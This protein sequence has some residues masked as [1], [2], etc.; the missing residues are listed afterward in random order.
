MPVP[1][2]ALTALSVA[3]S[4][5]TGGYATF[6]PSLFV[7][8]ISV[9]A[10]G[11]FLHCL[12]KEIRQSIAINMLTIAI[13]LPL[14]AWTLPALWLL[15][16]IMCLW[17]P[18]AAGRF[19]LIVPVYLFSLLLL[20]GLDK[21]LSIG[22]LSLFEFNVYNALALGAA[23]AIFFNPAK[24][25]SRPEWD[26]V[27]LS[28]VVLIAVALFRGT[29]L[30]HHAR[31]IFKLTIDLG[32]PYYVASRGLRNSSDLRMALIWL[33][34]G[35]VNASA[36]LIFEVW[37]G[38]PIYNQLFHIYELPTRLLVKQ[39]GGL[40]RAAGP[41]IE[42]TGGAMLLTLCTLALYVMRDAF[43]GRAHYYL[44]LCICLVGIFAPQS[45][46]A[47]GG[48][49]FAIVI[50]D[51][52]RRRY[53]PLAGKV[54]VLAGVMSVLLLTAHFSPFVSEQIGLSGGSR[55]TVDYRQVLFDRG[56]EEFAKR[57]FT[58]Y[59]MD[60]LNIH[61]QDLVQGEGII[62]FVNAYIWILLISGAGGLMIFLGAIGYFL[63][64]VTRAVRLGGR[65]GQAIEAGTFTVAAIAVFAEMFF[66]TSFGTR[67]AI[68]MLILFGFAVAYI[69]LQKSP[70]VNDP[71]V[72]EGGVT[73]AL[74]SG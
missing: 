26:V 18:V 69:R 4:L 29:S 27:A 34:A 1:I 23:V 35:A 30:S 31:G 45:R 6:K 64:K 14:L 54:A 38:W 12:K 71:S 63:W 70:V 32:L 9:L 28:I 8:I 55:D 21:T 65:G 57:P 53:F 11:L 15:F 37:K 7:V 41:F 46:S 51:I 49:L 74:T 3:L 44:L 39:R 48:L 68:F 20:P 36:I 61:L 16:V 43:R 72:E 66:F 40:L 47:W 10:C 56:L 73:A 2:I 33:A 22:S 17:V 19:G 25:R 24:A 50:V 52:L 60:E 5:L 42:P 59:T 58:G 67:P 62:D 13:A